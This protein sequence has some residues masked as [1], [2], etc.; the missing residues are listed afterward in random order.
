MAFTDIEKRTIEDCNK[1]FKESPRLI[2]L[3][4]IPPLCLLLCAYILPIYYNEILS[5]R[6]HPIN[7]VLIH[8]FSLGVLFPPVLVF[9]VYH[10]QDARF[11]L[12]F[13]IIFIGLFF[14]LLLSAILSF[15]EIE[16]S[17]LLLTL[18][19]IHCLLFFILCGLPLVLLQFPV[20]SN[21]A[22]LLLIAL[23]CI[24]LFFKLTAAMIGLFLLFCFFMQKQVNPCQ[25]PYWILI[26]ISTSLMFTFNIM[27]YIHSLFEFSP[28]SD[29]IWAILLFLGIAQP[30]VY[31]LYCCFKP[32]LYRWV[33][34]FH[35]SFMI[36]L[37]LALVHSSLW[38]YGA[39]FSLKIQAI[40][41]VLHY[42]QFKKKLL[43]EH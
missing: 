4:L 16:D 1:R 31:T 36:N 9:I 42:V 5:V 8:V 24:L 21:R 3:L 34:V 25:K 40:I 14:N 2:Y 37:I 33:L 26:F 18:I 39:G 15:L 17:A 10:W 12:Y 13:K 19:N 27:G 7:I 30:V 23:F 28:I 6:W 43:L 32:S 35:V 38:I 41:L 20:L 11:K 22:A 29:F